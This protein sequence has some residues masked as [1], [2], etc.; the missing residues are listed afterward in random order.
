MKK[1]VVK[2]FGGSYIDEEV[3]EQKMPKGP[4]IEDELV[5][6]IYER[7]S[8]AENLPESDEQKTTLD[9]IN[10]ME[11]SADVTKNL[12]VEAMKD[13]G[14]KMCYTGDEYVWL[15]KER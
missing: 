13:Y 15:L 8:P 1:K 6:L 3:D 9:L 7:Y 4:S 10:E 14:F 11:S 5:T 2:G 12:V